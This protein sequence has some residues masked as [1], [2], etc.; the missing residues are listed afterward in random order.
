[1]LGAC[2]LR[3]ESRAFSAG[4]A[5]FGGVYLLLVNWDWIGGQLGHDL[6]RGL[7]DLAESRVFPLPAGQ[8]Q[9]YFA[10]ETLQQRQ[11]RIGNFVQVVRLVFSVL[12]GL[13]GGWIAHAMAAR[14]RVGH[15]EA[16]P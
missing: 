8:N 1:V 13:A 12:F 16:P 2:F 10:F 5:L 7:S 6:T 9:G 3:G 11:A 4:F 14:S 15:S